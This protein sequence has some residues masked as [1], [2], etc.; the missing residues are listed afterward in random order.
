MA[1]GERDSD[2]VSLSFFSR[3]TEQ[4]EREYCFWVLY[5]ET[6]D[7]GEFEKNALKTE[8]DDFIQR[9]MDRIALPQYTA[10]VQNWISLQLFEGC[11]TVSQLT[12]NVSDLC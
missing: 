12:F 4:E 7:A 6:N 5:G 8:M 3:K 2:Q 11:S 10:R 1:K 9:G